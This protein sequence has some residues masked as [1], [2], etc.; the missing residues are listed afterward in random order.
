MGA[1]SWFGHVWLP[2]REMSKLPLLKEILPDQI[3]PF[4]VLF[5]AFL[6]AVGLDALYVHH[7]A[8]SSWLASR[9]RSLAFAATAAVGVVA[10]VPAFITFDV[11]MTVQSVRV[12]PYIRTAAP[13][14]PPHTVM[15]TIPFAVSGSTQPM[16][17]QAVDGMHFELA[18]AALKTPGP[19]GGPVGQGAPGSARRI[20][21]NLTVVGQREPSGTPA[22]LS[23][24]LQA[25]RTWRVDRVVVAGTSRDPVYATGFFTMALGVAPTEAD[26][27][28]VWTL[29]QGT[30][31][32]LPATGGSLSLCLEGTESTPPAGRAAAMAHC[33]LF[34]ASRV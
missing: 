13:T 15:L 1:P 12:P 16:L 25:L 26:G 23:T 21:T 22:Q 2:W 8:A 18:G 5:V 14:L 33:V 28:Q 9:R 34:G 6:V 7:R 3:A 10:L 17:W 27:A 31:M 11:P 4:I 30:P 29:T 19:L 24:V 32:A 20:L